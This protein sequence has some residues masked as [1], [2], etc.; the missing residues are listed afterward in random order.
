MRNK[1]IL[2]ASLIAG[3]FLIGFVPLRLNVGQQRD[4]I[5]ILENRLA[6]CELSNRLAAVR[7]L[8]ALT[9]LEANR[10]N[11]SLATEYSTRLFNQVR[12]MS[13]IAEPELRSAL[14]DALGSRDA[15]TASLA[16]GAPAS[17][18]QLQALLINLQENTKK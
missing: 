6:T 13:G 4:E 5:S 3:G 15:I 14:E 12:E 2:W 10:K 18:S 11:Y 8:A 1:L 17:A 7:D 16:K 9:Y